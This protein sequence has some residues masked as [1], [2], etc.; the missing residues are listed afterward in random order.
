[1]MDMVPPVEHV[2]YT[3]LGRQA[4]S[5]K[6]QLMAAVGAVLD[7][8]QYILGPEVSAFEREFADYCETTHAVGVA[9]GTDALHLVLR[10]L[11]VKAG[12]EVITAANSFIASA[13]SI[14]LAGA[15]PVFADI[16]SDL[17]LDPQAVE[18]AIT[19]RTKVIMPVHLAGR[20]ARMV[21]LLALAERHQLIIVEDA[22][23]A[24][25]ARLNGRRVGSWG[26]AA[27]FSFH[28]LKNL[29]AF[30][31]G[32]MVTTND[33]SL[34]KR[35]MQ[36][37]NH[38]LRNRNACEY[39][40]F[41]SRLDEV[42]AAMLRVQLRSLDRWT[43][44]RRSLAVRYHELLQPHVEVPLEGPGE[45]CVYQTYMVQADDRDALC[46]SLNTNQVEARIHYPVPIHL[47]LA[48][49]SLGYSSTDLPATVRAASRVLSLPL[50]P[51]L[52]SAQQDRVADVIAEFYARHAARR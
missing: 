4:A 35:L 16:G 6:P 3:A 22:A 39:W 23:Q 7:S 43:E 20:P 51:G 34:A 17:N 38:G 50:Y 36:T 44:E 27:C 32:G 25:G 10:A 48:A 11:G 18:A 15:R 28:P 41:N 9:N 14:A 45:Y 26:H 42:Q 31:D 40:S 33:P 29:H 5:V 1:M 30:G 47:Q 13:S 52:T 21:E 12:D 24:V 2:P 8:G 49:V 19:P 46:Q 37:R